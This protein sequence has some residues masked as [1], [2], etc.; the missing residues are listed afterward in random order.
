MI[1]VSFCNSQSFFPPSLL[2]VR[3]S[4]L[5]T[6]QPP[7]SLWKKMEIENLITTSGLGT[8]NDEWVAWDNFSMTFSPL[9]PQNKNFVFVSSQKWQKANDGDERKFFSEMTKWNAFCLMII[10]RRNFQLRHNKA[11]VTQSLENI[12]IFWNE[13]P[14]EE[15][16]ER[17][18]KSSRRR[19]KCFC[20]H[21]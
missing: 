11:I 13:I 5:M 2:T 14:D 8:H 17:T 4:L 7:D 19:G 3:R 15:E 12:F 1:A 10:Y 16:S 18:S 20:S 6:T 9:K 21:T